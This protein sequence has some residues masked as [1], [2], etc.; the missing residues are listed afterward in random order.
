MKLKLFKSIFRRKARDAQSVVDFESI[1]DLKK[2]L[3]TGVVTSSTLV[4]SCDTTVA[5]KNTD[6][7]ASEA[8]NEN[9]INDG[10]TEGESDV[11][12]DWKLP[13]FDEA[14][15]NIQTMEKEMERLLILRSF[16]LLDTGR[17]HHFD[18]IVQLAAEIFHAPIALISL[19][20]LGR[21][22]FLSSHGLDE[23]ITETPRSQEQ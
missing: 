18:R 12:V 2:A 23:S 7:D 5:S 14:T 13:K 10:G 15:T 11:I 9:N 21:Q 17:E 8:H 4:P 6:D 1:D 20:D 3:E 22:W 19:V 16:H